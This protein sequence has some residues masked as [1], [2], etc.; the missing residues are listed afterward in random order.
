MALSDAYATATEY[1]THTGKTDTGA[2][3]EILASLK[4]V[5]RWLDGKLGQELT[6]F[7]KDASDKT[8]VIT[9]PYASDTL[10]I[11]ALSASPTSITIDEDADGSFA[12]E[13]A[14]LA[15]D[16]IMLPE[17]ATVLPE[18]L[19]FD[20]IWLTTWGAKGTWGKGQRVQ[21]IGTWGWP[22][23]PGGIKEATLEFTAVL[24]RNSPLATNQIPEGFEGAIQAAP[25]A[26]MMLHGLTDKYRRLV[27]A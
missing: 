8:R 25:V 26:R 13:T 18:A 1:R 27:I 7:D 24:R 12:D 15:A 9:V 2:D 16:F 22:S 5:S 11:P 4:A 3:T 17:N 10:R 14:L 23:V 21:V 20:A 6:G 19:A